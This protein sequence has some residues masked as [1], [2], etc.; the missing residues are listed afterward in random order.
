MIEQS[1]NAAATR[2]WNH[3]GQGPAVAS[4]NRQVPMPATSMGSRGFWGLTITTAPDQAALMARC[5]A[6][7]T[8]L[9]ETFRQYGLS[10]LHHVLVA[11]AWGV[12]TGPPAGSVALKNGWLP[13]TDGWHV[14][15]IGAVAAPAA[16]YILAVLA[17][18]SSSIATM[19][20]QIATI[21]GVRGLSGPGSPPCP[22]C[23]PRA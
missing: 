20:R 19:A 23:P 21:E 6:P 4:F 7:S 5:A 12:S 8:L 13:R 18:D 16:S 11:Q 9:S 17:S 22:L 10:L 15:S 14:N 3:V 1:D 2:L